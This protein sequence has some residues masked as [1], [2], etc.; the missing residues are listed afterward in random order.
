MSNEI[1]VDFAIKVDER[2]NQVAVR[3]MRFLMYLAF[4]KLQDRG[5]LKAEVSVTKVGS[6]KCRPG[7]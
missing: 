5:Y 6:R 1:K 3:Y 7:L 2:K 4:K